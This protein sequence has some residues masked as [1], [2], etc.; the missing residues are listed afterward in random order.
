MSDSIVDPIFGA[1][2]AHR[3]AKQRVE[4]AFAEVRRVHQLADG[5]AFVGPDKGQVAR[6]AFIER[7]IGDE[8]KVRDGPCGDAWE[9]FVA[10]ANTVPSTLA[11]LVAMLN[12]ADECSAEE[13]GDRAHV[14]ISSLATAARALIGERKP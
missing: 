9:A 7:S 13:Y 4:M 6:R 11:G 3:A 5:M 1:I 10:F 2:E 12:Y 14:V 8:D